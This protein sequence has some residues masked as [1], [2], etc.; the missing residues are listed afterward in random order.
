MSTRT[1]RRIWKV[2]DTLTNVT[3]A[4][5]SDSTG[6]YGVKR[7]D[8]DAVISGCEDGT[9]MTNVSTGVYEKTFTEPSGYYGPYTA[10]VEIVYDGQT[11][12]FEHDLP[13]VPA[14]EG[15]VLT[16]TYSMLRREI[17]RFLG[18]GRDPTAW[19]AGSDEY[20][21]VEDALKSGIRRVVTP[22][23][24]PGE[25]YGHEW[26]FLR[27]VA[28]LTTTTPYSTGTVTI[29]DGVVTLDS[30]TFPSWAAQGAITISSGTY[31]VASRDSNT[32]VTL[33]DTTL[34][35]DAGSTYSL[36]RTVYD[37][38]DDFAMLDGEMVYATGSSVLRQTVERVSEKQVLSEL[39]TWVTASYPRWC[40]VRPKTID[41]TDHTLYEMVLCPT[42]DSAYTFY[43]HYRV[44][45]PSLDTSNT[46]P[47]GGDAHGELYLEA[48]LAAAEQKLHD[49]QG[50]H[51]ARFME[52]LIA[53][54]SHDRRVSCPDTLGPNRDYSDQPMWDCDDHR[55]TCTGL[56]RYKGYPT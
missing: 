52:C 54:V 47:P 21:D 29:A 20:V 3:T 44:A 22:P 26:S 46:T 55:L 51:S 5:L 42:P 19:A 1:I 49:T 39:T 16:A 33:T 12:R 34:D 53:S 32:Q 35:A 36:G 9:D 25:K 31:S 15:S 11:Y 40:A 38:P 50:L 17:G 37:L 27:P 2:N 30:G 28:T 4:K 56:T 45:I 6:T 13:A 43:Y 8:T 14:S 10:W 7:D 41:M 23:P 48:C 18:Y 24:I